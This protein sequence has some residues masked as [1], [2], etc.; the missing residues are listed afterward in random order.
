MYVEKYAAKSDVANNQCFLMSCDVD[1]A[2]QRA[3]AIMGFYVHVLL[4]FGFWVLFGVTAPDVRRPEHERRPSG[5][6]LMSRRRRRDG[7]QT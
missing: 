4:L 3:I 5:L 6:S 1:D 7:L 2:S